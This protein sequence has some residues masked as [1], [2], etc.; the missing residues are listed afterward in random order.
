V[1]YPIRSEKQDQGIRYDKD[2]YY[3]EDDDDDDEDEYDDYT[4]KDDENEAYEAVR[5]VLS[6]LSNLLLCHGAEIDTGYDVKFGWKA[7]HCACFTGN[8]N[9]VKMLLSHYPGTIDNVIQS[10]IV[11]KG[12]NQT[13]AFHVI[14]RESEHF[15]PIINL[16]LQYGA[17]INIPNSDGNTVLH[18]VLLTRHSP[19]RD[20]FVRFLLDDC[21]AN[22][23]VLKNNNGKTAWD[24]G[25]EPK[26]EFYFDIME[27]K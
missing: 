22:F 10:E 16:L 3:S 14:D 7:I 20:Q 4:R 11:E 19:N 17:D 12:K 23:L 15:A 18:S 25:L 1:R 27:Q 24:I 2:N 21:Q 6:N 8:V 26:K 13:T 5:S 9:L